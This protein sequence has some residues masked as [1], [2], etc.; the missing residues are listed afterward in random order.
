MGFGVTLALL[1]VAVAVFALATYLSRRPLPLGE[2]RLIP[3]TALQFIALLVAVLMLAH[4][5]TL[6]SGKPFVGRMGGRL[7]F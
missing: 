5:I 3:Y 6:V 1:A 2:V 4:L 7:G